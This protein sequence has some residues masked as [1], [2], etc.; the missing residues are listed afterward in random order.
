[1]TPV[2]ETPGL[3]AEAEKAVLGS[4]L[5]DPGTVETMLDRLRSSSFGVTAHQIIFAEIV[6]AYGDTGPTDWLTIAHRFERSGQL[7]LVGGVPFLHELVDGARPEQAG[8]HAAIVAQA[9]TERDIADAGARLS[10]AAHILDPDRRD[11]VVAAIRGQLD[12]LDTTPGGERDTWSPVDLAPYLRGEIER[13]VPTVGLVRTDGLR[14]IYPGKEHAVI[15]EMEAGKSF[16]SLACAFAELEAGRDVV[17]IHFEE[18]DP[19]D[20]IERLQGFGATDDAIM[21]RF[22]FVGPEYPVTPERLK[23]LLDPV[24]S[25]VILDGVNEGMALHGVEVREEAGAAEFRRRLVKPC[26]RVGAAVLSCD[27]VVKDRERR[28]RYQLG[29]I[30]KGNALTGSLILLENVEPFG[31]GQRGRSSVFVTKDRSGH[32]RRAGQATRLPG[33]TYMGELV[34]DDTRAAA[35]VQTLGFFAPADNAPEPGRDRQPDQVSLADVEDQK[36]LDAIKAL[37]AEGKP[38][39][40]RHVISKAG[41]SHGKVV[42]GLDRL[43]IN[44]N[45]II[46]MPGARGA[47]IY[48]PQPEVEPDLSVFQDPQPDP[49]ALEFDL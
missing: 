20:T 30:H 6:A 38:A 34:V 41:L 23:R 33:K 26:T 8:Y 16:F 10:Q 13:P 28:D 3:V 35:D 5:L 2:D 14:L 29:S 22:R 15:G 27:H 21:K 49:P 12:D 4:M 19:S 25:L 11:R 24:P 42:A 1:M 45:R 18:S 44:G 31:R 46:E 32:L 43:Q 9:A 48:I 40:V 39:N 47:R 17:Y 36:I 37:V 7:S